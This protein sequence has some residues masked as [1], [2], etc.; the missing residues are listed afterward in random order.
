MNG[1]SRDKDQGQNT[2]MHAIRR[3]AAFL[4]RGGVS[5]PLL[6][7][8]VLLA[9]GTTA[10]LGYLRLAGPPAAGPPRI[11]VTPE[12]IEF[13]EISPTEKAVVEYRVRNAGGSPLEIT[14][15]STSCG[16][17]TAEVGKTTLLPGETTPLRVTF[18]PQ[19]MRAE[20]LNEEDIYRIIFLRS[21]DPERPEV[22]VELRGRVLPSDS[23]SNSN[24]EPE[25]AVEGR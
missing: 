12:L 9:L 1:E 3:R 25:S 22:T 16:C 10:G 21:N 2:E 14:R 20:G 11:E 13:G 6:I 24:S 15:V 19:A 4:S 5:L 23:D 8:G 17:T 7:I 18:D